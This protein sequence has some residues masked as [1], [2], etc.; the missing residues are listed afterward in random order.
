MKHRKNEPESMK[1]GYIQESWSFRKEAW[2]GGAN[3]GE[4]WEIS[5]S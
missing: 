2:E 4:K 5:I 1:V 3:E